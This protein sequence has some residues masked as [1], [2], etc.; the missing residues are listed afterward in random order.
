MYYDFGAAAIENRVSGVVL[1]LPRI[2]AVRYVA[3]YRLWIRFN[4]GVEGEVNLDTELTG[5]V[6][7]P[8]RDVAEFQRLRLDS[9]LRTIVWPN[10]ADLAPEFLRSKLQANA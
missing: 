4:D 8:L 7:E 10:G 5:P 6:F 3:D 1:M 9:D 2:V